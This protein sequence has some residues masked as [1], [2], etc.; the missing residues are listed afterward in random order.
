MDSNPCPMHWRRR[1]ATEVRRVTVEDGGRLLRAWRQRALEG[2]AGLEALAARA[3]LAL[4]TAAVA[5][6]MIAR[7]GADRVGAANW[8]RLR[9]TRVAGRF[10]LRRSGLAALL[11]RPE[12]APKP[13]RYA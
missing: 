13:G 6:G 1:L 9:P 12:R 7:R 3:A 5:L 10:A 4:T 2:A 11:R 8:G